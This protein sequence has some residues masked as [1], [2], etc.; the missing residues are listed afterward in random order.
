MTVI[1]PFQILSCIAIAGLAVSSA[2]HA[3]LK[4]G[5]TFASFKPS[6]WYFESSGGPDLLMQNSRLE[7]LVE[8]PANTNFASL[9]WQPNAGGYNQNWFVEVEV[10]LG[11]FALPGDGDSQSLSLNVFPSADRDLRLFSV[12]LNQF[13]DNGRIFRGIAVRDTRSFELAGLSDARTIR[14]RLHHDIDSRNITPSWNAGSGWEYGG[15]RDVV[16]WNMKSSEKFLVSLAAANGA[17]IA[18]NAKVLSGQAWFKNFKTGNASPEIVVERSPTSEIKSNKGLIS[19]GA[20]KTGTGEITKS[21]KIRNHGTARLEGLK[22]SVSGAG[23]K[24]FNLSKL[25][26]TELVPGAFTTF[27]VTFNPKLQGSSKAKV[28]LT[29]TDSDESAFQINVSGRGVD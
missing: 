23:A 12:T 2:A 27:R 1:K 20:A 4:G 26:K 14:L 7:Y 25:A 28:F 13:R 11:D 18:E 5:D 3:D 16:G 29:S 17:A 21:F 22:L 9:I 24:D 10:S 15:S 6:N 8:A 19:F